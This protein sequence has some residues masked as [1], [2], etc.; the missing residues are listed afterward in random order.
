MISRWLSRHM[1]I[2][3]AFFPMGCNRPFG[4]PG[5]RPPLKWMTGNGK[6]SL[7][8]SLDDQTIVDGYSIQPP[9]G[10]VKSQQ[11]SGYPDSGPYHGAGRSG[12][13]EAPRRW[14]L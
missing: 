6:E 7:L 4:L 1:L 12:R 13:T 14:C 2:A 3:L 8:K 11:E 5:A 10:Y 9:K